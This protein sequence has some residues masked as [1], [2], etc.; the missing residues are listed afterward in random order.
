MHGRR[1]RSPSSVPGSRRWPRGVALGRGESA[2]AQANIEIGQTLSLHSVAEGIE[3]ARQ[4]DKLVALGCGLGR[5]YHLSKP[6]PAGG[7]D[8]LLQVGNALALV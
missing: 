6:V 2:L 8:A 7:I 4:I 5:G 3:D 1:R